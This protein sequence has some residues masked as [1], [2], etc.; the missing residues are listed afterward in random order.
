MPRKPAP[1]PS[2]ERRM[3]GF[4][5]A[6]GFVKEPIRHAGES[7]GFAVARLLTHWEEVVGAELARKT[8]PV[9]IGYGR[10]GLGA[11]LTLLTTG[12][13]APMIEMQKDRIREKVNAVYGYNAIARI[14]LTQTAATGFAEGQATFSEAG[15]AAPS[16]RPEVVQA[17]RQTAAP[18]RDEG[19]RQALETLALNV[20]NR[21][22]AKESE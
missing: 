4:E 20:L 2:S 10:E 7:R 9:K 13:E 18:I 1:A 15:R 14:H 3:R 22:K 11:T 8:R 17:A 12:A 6:F 5:P 16:P 19:L 21:R